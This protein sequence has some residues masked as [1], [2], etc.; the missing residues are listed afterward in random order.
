MASAKPSDGITDTIWRL[1]AS[2]QLTIVLLLSLAATSI[3]GT[4][5]PQNESPS[6][7]VKAFG[8]FYF[9]FF[10]ALDLFD[11]Y[12]SWWFLLLLLLL[13]L[14]IIICSIDRIMASRKILFVRQPQFKFN[15][16]NNAKALKQLDIPSAPETLKQN[17]QTWWQRKFARVQLT[18]SEDGFRLFAEKGRWTRF[19]VY[20]VHLSVVILLLGGMI[21]SLFGFEG[22]VNLAP[23]DSADRIR[24]RNS[25]QS[26]PLGFTV[27]CEDF[28]VSFYDNGAPE[29]FQSSLSII[30]NGTTM[31]EK[32]IIVNDPL[33]Y[34]GI[35]FYQ[36]SYG[37]LPPKGAKLSF[38]SKASAQVYEREAIIGKAVNLPENLGVFTLKAFNNSAQFQGQNIGEAFM[39]VLSTSNG[40]DQQVIL[41]VRF[42][43]FDRMRGGDVQ[44]GVKDSLLNYYTGLEVSSDPGVWV[45]Y[46]GFILMILGCYIT[47][48]MSHQQYCLDVVR[49]KAESRVS[50]IGVTNKNKLA[51]PKKIETLA[52]DLARFS[53]EEK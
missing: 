31:V 29:L 22:F 48:F 47:F 20:I 25:N 6:E 45:V 10:Q 34:K 11:M 42:P 30:E 53:R 41:P 14:N 15:R 27:R 32:D 35:S 13:V 8:D 3:I 1:F 5:I 46:T 16:F 23:G 40:K 12:H 52:A 18:D 2:V 26:L 51:M 4:L 43:S 50:I 38:T 21:G 19:G 33:R 49:S 9:R 37:P 39:G 28:I 24:L 17:Y 7:Y 44:I 36:A